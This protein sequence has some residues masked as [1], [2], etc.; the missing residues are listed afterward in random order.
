MLN[1]CHL[2]A[3]NVVNDDISMCEILNNFFASVFT[4]QESGDVPEVSMVFNGD[5]S[6]KLSSII[7]TSHNCYE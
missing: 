4:P 6:Q 1:D 7:I 2:S 3:G 5:V